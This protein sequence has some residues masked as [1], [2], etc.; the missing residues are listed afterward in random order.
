MLGGLFLRR[1]KI[2]YVDIYQLI[3][4]RGMLG[5]LEYASKIE[6]ENHKLASQIDSAVTQMYR[7]ASGVSKRTAQFTS[8]TFRNFDIPQTYTPTYT[9]SP[10]QAPSQPASQSA[11]PASAYS[12]EDPMA[13]EERDWSNKSNLETGAS[14]ASGFIVLNKY[15]AFKLFKNSLYGPNGAVFKEYQALLAKGASLS[16]AETTKLADILSKVPRYAYIQ[17]GT[18]VTL[19]DEYT[20]LI[21]VGKLGAQNVETIISKAAETAS[22]PSQG[23]LIRF[24]HKFSPVKAGKLLDKISWTHPIVEEFSPGLATG[25]QNENILKSLKGKSTSEALQHLENIASNN[26]K[27]IKSIIDRFSAQGVST[28]ADLRAIGQDALADQVDNLLGEAGVATKFKNYLGGKGIDVGKEF[29]SK[30]KGGI[31]AG[32]AKAE[33]NE[34]LLMGIFSKIATKYPV[35]AG[36]LRLLSKVAG[37]LAV[38]LEAKGAFDEYKESGLTP[39]FMCNILSLILGIVTTGSVMTG[40]G[41]P[42][43]AVT[44]PLWGVVSIGCMFFPSED[45]DKKD[46]PTQLTQEDVDKREDTVKWDDLSDKDKAQ[47]KEILQSAG[48][49]GTVWQNLLQTK[50]VNKSL[51]NPLDVAALLQKERNTGG[52]IPAP[53]Q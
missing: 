51:E 48:S 9:Q 52:M 43:A 2:Y 23:A 47:A 45:K 14:L 27:E 49:G 41:A 35:L 53:A 32:A 36:S 7:N 13:Q 19:I 46:R 12:Y 40:I 37:P 5:A 28:S 10:A 44:G 24:L 26:R 11:S 8:G 39:R 50:I 42:V 6:G 17:N 20:K 25:A 18:P 31:A 1:Q 33:A 30:T 34:G 21:D 22:R 15:Q 16:P 29:L 4:E 3:L 38:A